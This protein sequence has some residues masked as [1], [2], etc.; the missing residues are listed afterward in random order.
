VGEVFEQVLFAKISA[1]V[2][3][4]VFVMYLILHYSEEEEKNR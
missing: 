3:L 4:A 1:I 2:M